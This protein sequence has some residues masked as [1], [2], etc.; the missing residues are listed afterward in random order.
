MDWV[1]VEHREHREHLDGASRQDLKRRFRDWAR[2]ENPGWDI[3]GEEYG[4]GSWYTFFFQV[5]E[6][7]LLSI[8]TGSDAYPTQGDGRPYVNTVRGWQDADVAATDEDWIK[9]QT[10]MLNPGFYVE[11]NNDEAWYTFYTPPNGVCRWE[12]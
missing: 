2:A 8:A 10:N 7:A 12:E 4:R 9:I 3:D 1:F 11:L 6:P 5:D